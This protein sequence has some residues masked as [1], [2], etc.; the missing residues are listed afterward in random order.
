MTSLLTELRRRYDYVVLDTPPALGLTDAKVAALLADAV[1]FAVRWEK[2]KAEVALNGLDALADGHVTVTGLVLTQVNLRRH[3]K[4]GYNDIGQYYS[5]Y[6]KY[7]A[8]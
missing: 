4:Y 5:T 6:K 3:A 8:N 7:Y 2:T 1:L